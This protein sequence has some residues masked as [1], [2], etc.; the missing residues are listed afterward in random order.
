MNIDNLH[1]AYESERGIQATCPTTGE[2]YIT[3]RARF[4][5]SGGRRVVSC[6][7]RHCD[8]DRRIRTDPQFN[9]SEP[10]VHTYFLSDTHY[11]EPM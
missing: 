7:C 8:A 3:S 1:L 4:S 5:F 6:D 10:H 9:P 11:A 2:A